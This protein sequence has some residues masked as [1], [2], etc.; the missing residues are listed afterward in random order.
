M[1]RRMLLLF[2]ISLNLSI[3]C[4]AQKQFPS[5]KL[6][7]TPLLTSEYLWGVANRPYL[8]V[9]ESPDSTATPKE[10]LR[11][12]DI[13]RIVSKVAVGR[14]RSYWFEVQVPESGIIG[15]M[16]DENISVYNSSAQA[17]TAQVDIQ[18]NE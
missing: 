1:N 13:V 4:R 12:G 15:W 8:R 14:D 3:S 6:P 10:V 18:A 7:P 9:L 16:P 11:Q 17:R 2:C 5:P